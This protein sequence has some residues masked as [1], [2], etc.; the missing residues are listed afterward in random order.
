MQELLLHCVA[1]DAERL[2]ILTHAS[3]P[4]WRGD[5]RFVGDIRLDG[6]HG[7]TC[8]RRTTATCLTRSCRA[9]ASRC[10]SGARSICFL[11]AKSE[12]WT[13]F[14][15]AD[16]K[17]C[18][19]PLSQYVCGTRRCCREVP[20]HQVHRFGDAIH[21]ASDVGFVVEMLSSNLSFAL[22]ASLTSPVPT[23]LSSHNSLWTVNVNATQRPAI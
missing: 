6:A 1:E 14:C 10:S 8:T 3:W 15:R 21:L 9:S 13:F 17:G 20:S 22:A 4:F 11:H 18:P 19:V 2:Y 16:A 5:L 7:R 12:L 23:Q